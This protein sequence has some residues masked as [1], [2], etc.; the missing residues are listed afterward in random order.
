M[1]T[2]PDDFTSES[3]ANSL[4][5]Y[6]K[7]GAQISWT[8]S[9]NAA[10]QFFTIG[11]SLI[12]GPDFIPGAGRFPAFFDQY[13]FTDYTDYV[14]AMNV[15]RNIGQYP[16]GAVGADAS[17]TL[18]NT[19]LMFLPG[20]DPVIGNDITLGRPMKLSVGYGDTTIN[21]FSGFSTMPQNQI[22]QR[23]IVVGAFDGMDTL[24]NFIS[25]GSGPLASLNNGN[26]VDAP[27]N[28][29][30]ADLLT[31]AGLNTSEYILENSLQP[32]IGY[33]C[34]NSLLIG[35][36]IRAFCEAEQ[37]IFLFDE[38]GIAHFWNRQHV[39]NNQASL[40]TFNE[41]D[42]LFD[43]SYEQTPVINDVQF[44]GNPRYVDVNQQLYLSS[45]YVTIPAPSDSTVLSNLCTNPNFNTNVTNWSTPGGGTLTYSNL[46]YYSGSGSAKLVSTGATQYMRNTVTVTTNNTYVAQCRVQGTAGTVVKFQAFE[47]G[48]LIGNLSYT[49]DTNWDL[50]VMPTIT[51]DNVNTSVEFRIAPNTA[52]TIYVD[53]V[54]ITT[55]GS[56]IS[57]YWDG[58][59]AATTTHI[60]SWSG[61]VNNSTSVATPVGAKVVTL[62]FSDADGELPVVSTDTLHWYTDVGATSKYRTNTANDNTG[63]DTQ[64]FTT[65]QSA[66]LSTQPSSAT[67]LSSSSYTV[68][69]LN[70]N[71]VPIYLTELEVW[72]RPAKLREAINEEY[73]NQ[74][75]MVIYGTN[76]ANNGQ[77]LQFTN[78]LVQSKDTAHSNAFTLVQDFS[79]PYQ[80]A[81]ADVAPVPQLQIGDTVTIGSTDVPVTTVSPMGMLMSLTQTQNN[82]SYTEY[83]VVGIGLEFSADNLMSQK[84]ELEVRV[85][86]SY[87]T[88]ASSAIGGNDQI[89]P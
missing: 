77:P 15:S 39:Y 52:D 66:I 81:I 34:P 57:G 18:D 82:P 38:N 64:S 74:A 37:A 72:G 73:Q 5:H 22:G 65:I 21:V 23:L 89:A 13:Q 20:Y 32:N 35:D 54:L 16:Y 71:T 28:L 51:T 76:P 48:V 30:I 11:T 43:L 2:V 45:S 56:P 41:D 87:F 46:V 6:P 84:L 9:Q 50:L 10:Y 40:W 7:F 85:L 60:Y 69:V 36:I 19:S 86:A 63:T 29:I 75:S 1:Q 8:K 78:D 83:T 88:I 53:E 42:A 67:S 47:A 79:T 14:L 61:T 68:T 62:T 31:E 24:N 17:V 3:G 80:R 12:G 26:Y 4:L 27:A 59:S 55:S 44:I 25:T 33:F 70:S 49:L 58:S